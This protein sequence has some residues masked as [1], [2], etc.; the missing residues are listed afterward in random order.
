MDVQGACGYARSVCGFTSF[1]SS[2]GKTI[3]TRIADA[4]QEAPLSASRGFDAIED[5]DQ[6]RNR[7]ISPR[8]PVEGDR[9]CTGAPTRRREISNRFSRITVFFIATIFAYDCV[10]APRRS[11]DRPCFASWRTLAHRGDKLRCAE[12]WRKARLF[13]ARGS[14]SSRRAAGGRSIGASHREAFTASSTC[15]ARGI[16]RRESIPFATFPRAMSAA[17]GA[18]PARSST[19]VSASPRVVRAPRATARGP[20]IACRRRAHPETPSRAPRPF[21]PRHA[22]PHP[23]ARLTRPSLASHPLLT[24]PA[25]LVSPRSR[26]EGLSA[27][28][29]APSIS[30]S[31][32]VVCSARTRVRSIASS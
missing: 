27:P 21:P 26:P 4:W 14:S 23:G 1:P 18:P 13:D 16:E 29:R 8:L 15:A 2:R 22:V 6:S 19:R 9:K 11:S 12:W 25:R 17:L 5:N 10:R 7:G 32:F 3:P 20:P 31:S 28:P 30:T 24:S